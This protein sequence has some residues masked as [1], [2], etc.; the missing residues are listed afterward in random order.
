MKIAGV[1]IP[2]KL[3][4]WLRLLWKLLLLLFVLFILFGVVFGVRRI[5]GVTMDP[6]LKDGELTLFTRLWNSYEVGDAVLYE[7]D[8]QTE[9]SRI[10]AK[11]GQIITVNESGYLEV[12]GSEETDKA[13]FDVSDDSFAEKAA[14]FPYRV[15]E[16]SYYLLNDNYEYEQDSRSFGAVY[17][18][19]LRGKIISTLKV[20]N[21]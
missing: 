16:G 13:V 2:D 11:G 6:N 12:D 10:V 3:R 18:K 14:K 1:Q 9:V 21:I 8:G 20:R 15:P 4:P 5:S 19:D 17:E 7:R